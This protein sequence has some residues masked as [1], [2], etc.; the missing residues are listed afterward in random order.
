MEEV[1]RDAGCAAGAFEG[2]ACVALEADVAPVQPLDLLLLRLPRV[3]A[4]AQSV[5]VGLVVIG[6]SIVERHDV[7][8]FEG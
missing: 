2:W 3:A 1:G 4:R 7:V 8:D 6:P 5:A